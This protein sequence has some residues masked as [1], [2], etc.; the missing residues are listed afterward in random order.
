MKNSSLKKGEWM[1]AQSKIWLEPLD[2]TD[3]S[4]E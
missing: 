4:K 3:L 1:T 2:G